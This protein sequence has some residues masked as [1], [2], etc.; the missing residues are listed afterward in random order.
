VI[1]KNHLNFKTC[2]ITMTQLVFQYAIIQLSIRK[3]ERGT[4]KATCTMPI[5]VRKIKKQNFQAVIISYEANV[6]VSK[7]SERKQVNNYR[8]HKLHRICSRACKETKVS[9]SYSFPP[10]SIF[11]PSKENTFRGK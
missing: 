1:F 10:F 6:T 3:Q 7:R 8:L 9:T 5:H 2:H 11:V 4:Q